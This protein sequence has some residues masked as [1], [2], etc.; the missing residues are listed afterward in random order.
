M[1]SYLQQTAFFMVRELFYIPYI[2][3]SIPSPIFVISILL[4]L[5]VAAKE[6]ILA[7]FSLPPVATLCIFQELPQRCMNSGQDTQLMNMLNSYQQHTAAIYMCL[8]HV[9]QRNI[10]IHAVLPATAGQTATLQ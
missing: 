10:S 8:C 5:F 2:L 6:G 3:L 4:F 9:T 7:Y 1:Y